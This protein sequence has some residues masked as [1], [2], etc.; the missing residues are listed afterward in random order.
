VRADQHRAPPA[1]RQL[2]EVLAAGPRDG[3]RRALTDRPVQPV[4]ARR[5]RGENARK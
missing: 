4:D 2:L 3:E 5:A 1:L